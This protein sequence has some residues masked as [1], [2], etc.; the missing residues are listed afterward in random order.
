MFTANLLRLL[1]LYICLIVKLQLDEPAQLELVLQVQDK[2]SGRNMAF[3]L[4][5]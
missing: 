4:R 1:S 3:K 5:Y 2:H